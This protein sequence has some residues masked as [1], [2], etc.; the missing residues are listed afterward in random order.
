[1]SASGSSPQGRGTLTDSLVERCERRF[2]PAGAGNTATPVPSLPCPPVHPRRGGEHLPSTRGETKG[3]GSSPQGRGTRI[4]KICPRCGRRFIPAGAGNTYRENMPPLRAAVHPRRGGEHTGSIR[5]PTRRGG[6]SPQGRGTPA[7]SMIRRTAHRF[8]PAGAGNTEI[9]ALLEQG[10][11]VHP[12]R[13]G[14][15]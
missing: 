12:R 6:S 4:G 2:I 15:H 8:I 5:S 1:M 14:E 11:P 10:G 13:G 7:L 9:P 3:D